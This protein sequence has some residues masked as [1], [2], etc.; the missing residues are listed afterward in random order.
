NQASLEIGKIYT[1]TAVPIGNWVFASW[2]SGTNTNS[3]SA[4]TGGASLAFD[5]SSNLTLQAN[6]VTNPFTAVAGVYNGL[7]SPTSGVSQASSGFI[8]ATIPASSHGA[9]SAKL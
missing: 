4:L 8:T 5:M 1:V 7:F 3:L 2:K 9:Y 6:F